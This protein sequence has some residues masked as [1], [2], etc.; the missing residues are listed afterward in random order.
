VEWDTEVDVLCIG[1]GGGALAMAIAAVDAGADVLMT[2][3]AGGN[4]PSEGPAPVGGLLG[5]DVGDAE[6]NEYF[7]ALSEGLSIRRHGGAPTFEVPIRVVDDR[8][9]TALASRPVAPFVGARLRDWAAS[10]L[11]SPYG[12]I[13]SRVSERKAIT[14]RSSS[15]ESFEFASVGSIELGPDLPQLSLADWLL[16]QAADRGIEVSARPSLQRIVFEDGQVVGAALDTPSGACA[17]RARRGVLMSTGGRDLS[18]TVSHCCDDCVTMQVC[19]VR[20][21]P[22][23]FGRVELL[24]S[25]PLN[26]APHTTCRPINRRLIDTARETKQ[27]HSSNRCWGEVHRY[28]PLGE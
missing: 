1:S 3:S 8:S 17:V 7:H 4:H 21:T 27:S 15:G 13:Y 23:R 11:A 16:A 28:P 6:T 9:T 22:S 5:I 25:G 2:D 10:C 12:L 20:Q 14:M 26:R 24:T 19:I 18:V